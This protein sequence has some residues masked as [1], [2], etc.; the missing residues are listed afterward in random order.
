MPS[1]IIEMNLFGMLSP[2]NRID[3]SLFNPSSRF[4][5][6]AGF[7]MVF[8]TPVYLRAGSGFSIESWVR[9]LCR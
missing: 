8:N 2:S 7:F 6:V 5:L 9:V 3:F 1:T 4:M